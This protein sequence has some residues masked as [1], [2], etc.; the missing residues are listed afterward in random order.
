MFCDLVGSSELAQRLDPETYVDCVHRYH[1][2]C[3]ATMERFGGYVAQWLGDGALVY[4]GYPRAH[5]NDAERAVLAGLDF[6]AALG[7]LSRSLLEAA[8]T[9]LAVRI[10]LHT[11]PVVLGALGTGARR[12]TLALG[13]TTN[14]AARVQAQAE[15]NTVVVTETTLRLVEGLFVTRDLGAPP[16]K[17]IADRIRLSVVDRRSAARGRLEGA[18]Q[19]SPMV[20]RAAELA[21]LLRTH[22][23]AVAGRLRLVSITGEPGLGKS[24]IAAQLREHVARA[25]HHW[26]TLRCSPLSA[27]ALHPWVDRLRD[28]FGVAA[29]EMPEATL[30]RLRRGLERLGP[31][32]PETAERFARLLGVPLLAGSR[33]GTEALELARQRVLEALVAW[34]EELAREHPTVLL[35]EDLHW[36]DPSTVQWIRL[37]AERIPGS[38]VLCVL[39]QRPEFEA[40][41]SALGAEAIVLGRIGAEDARRLVQHA[42][43]GAPLAPRLVDTI[44]ERADGVPLFLEELVRM[45]RASG[46]ADTDAT[47]EVPTTL[48]DL[49]MARLDQ[50]GAAKSVA[51]IGAV[52]GRDFSHE[53][54]AEIAGEDPSGLEHSLDSIVASGLIFRS[55]AQRDAVY[56]FKHALVQDTAYESLLR[57]RRIELHRAAALALSERAARGSDVAPALLGHHWRGAE[58]WQRAAD[59]F[60]AAGRRAAG[61]AAFE[62]AIT[63]YRDGI[64]AASKAPECWER[65]RREVSLNIMLG[66]SLMAVKG[67]NFPECIGLWERAASLAEAIGEP[68]ELSGARNGAAVFH[69]TNG[70]LDEAERYARAVIDVA[71][72]GDARIGGLR[73][74]MSLATCLFFRGRGEEALAHVERAIALYRPSDFWTVTYG[75]SLDQGVG[76]YAMAGSILA[77]LGRLDEAMRHAEEGLA[78]AMTLRSPLS[79]MMARS[80]LCLVCVDRGDTER[81]RAEIGDIHGLATRHSLPMGMG[82]AKL[83][84]GYLAAREGDPDGI[85]RMME[86]V[87]LQGETVGQSGATMGMCLL[88]SAYLGVGNH[89]AAE[90]LVGA[91]LALAETQQIPYYRDQLLVLKAEIALARDPGA[92]DAARELLRTA[93]SGARA[94]GAKLFEVRAALRLARLLHAAR[95]DDAARA[96]LLESTNGFQGEGCTDG[97][98]LRALLGELAPAS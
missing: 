67:F 70:N 5:E 80:T 75:S 81:V 16:L 51:Q 50:L 43:E 97:L 49:L 29:G 58:E 15:P 3:A 93:L 52:I 32:A 89:E 65:Q 53:L 46:A 95:D 9:Q 10:G 84:E 90:G 14:V 37:L 1:E 77:W 23:E 79:I 83:F 91:G 88:A 19:L 59:Q 56:T 31:A 85:T 74:H 92:T 13:N 66:N 24:R 8:G 69:L 38:R 25:P 62:E 18:R 61:S 34:V 73:G 36:S 60:D 21:L 17:G 72:P 86:G 94:S 54:L 98:A 20:G 22:D 82:F 78:L 2:A 7:A 47:L 48:R 44:V 68:D 12:E 30:A 40:P 87:A 57:R 26:L 55:G 63:H 39:T 27:D 45:V 28:D 41:W 6:V 71:P 33:I 4:F 96:L 35:V 11:G 42:A 76:S 64:E